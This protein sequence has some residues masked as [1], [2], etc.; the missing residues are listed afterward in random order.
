MHIQFLKSYNINN[1]EKTI[2]IVSSLFKIELQKS[3][4]PLE[5]RTQFSYKII[6]EG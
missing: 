1:I 4:L 6:N 5:F 2:P 3:R